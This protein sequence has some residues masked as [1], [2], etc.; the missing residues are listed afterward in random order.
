MYAHRRN[1]LPSFLSIS[2][3][4]KLKQ[5]DPKSTSFASSNLKPSLLHKLIDPNTNFQ[6]RRLRVALN[7]S[8][9]IINYSKSIFIN[10]K[11]NNNS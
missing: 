3:V 11:S 5:V 7:V 1:I 9:M 8:S 2:I 4:G 6:F 10:T